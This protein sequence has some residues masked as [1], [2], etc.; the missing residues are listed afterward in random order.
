MDGM[1]LQP[2]L[3][4]F[5]SGRDAILDADMINNAGANECLIWEAFAGRGMG[6]SADAGG[7]GNTDGIE[8]FDLPPQCGGVGLNVSLS[9]SCPGSMTVEITGATAGATVA[10][11]IGSGTD[12]TMLPGGPCAGTMIDLS[13]IG[14]RRELTAD[15]TGT[16]SFNAEPGAGICG[17]LIQAVDFATCEASAIVTVP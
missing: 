6:F 12:G 7:T 9:G 15:P 1:K 4:T 10:I 3:P 2:C 14:T 5:E 8:A 13:G 17:G 16:V 11:G